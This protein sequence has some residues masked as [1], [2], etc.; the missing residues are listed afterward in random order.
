MPELP[1]IETVKRTLTPLLCGRSIAN[2]R[3]LRPDIIKHP[4]PESFIASLTGRRIVELSRRG[5]Y[6]LIHMEDGGTLAAHLRMTGR[7]VHAE[8][9][10]E[11]LPHTH[12]VFSLDDGHEL[13]FSDMRRFGCL[14]LIARGETDDFTGMARL[15]A[16]PLSGEFSAAYIMERLGGRRLT[17]KQGILDQSVIAGLGNIYADEALFAAAVLPD[18]PCMSLSAAEWQ[19]IAA[20]IPPIL[21]SAIAHKGTTFSD[22]LDGEG[23][24]GENL[25][26]LQV[27]HRSGQP[28]KRCGAVI[29]KTKVGGRGTCYCAGCQK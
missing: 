8:A 20:V 25:Q 15:G 17:V 9:G 13:R 18:R 26:Y 11:A 22:Y 29:Q 14:W 5:K 7:F 28:C 27:Y 2:I 21:E 23:K 10:A 3:A 19:A 4:D 16:E 24:A 1:E 12:V 6:L